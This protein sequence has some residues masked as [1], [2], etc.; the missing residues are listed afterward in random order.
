MPV[1]ILLTV[2]FAAVGV[3]VFLVLM[4]MLI[5]GLNGMSGAA[6]QPWLIGAALIL[7]VV[8][9][10]GAGC[11]LSLISRKLAGPGWSVLA[12]S[13]WSALAFIAQLGLAALLWRGLR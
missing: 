10:L 1:L 13:G 9:N 11:L 8:P 12:A 3:S 2:L 5:I 4:L 6:A 7:F